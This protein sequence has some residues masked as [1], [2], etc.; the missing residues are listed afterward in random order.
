MPCSIVVHF[1]E[2]GQVRFH[3]SLPYTLP[4]FKTGFDVDTVKMLMGIFVRHLHIMVKRSEIMG[5]RFS[6]CRIPIE[7][8]QSAFWVRSN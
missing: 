8:V 2:T 1:Q 3:I 6:D 7:V 5:F 4:T